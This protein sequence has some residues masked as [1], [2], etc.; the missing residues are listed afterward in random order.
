MTL[1]PSRR[2]SFSLK[3]GWKKLMGQCYR[4]LPGQFPGGDAMNLKLCRFT[5]E[6]GEAVWINPLQI[7]MVHRAQPRGSQTGTR[8]EF[9]EPQYVFVRESPEEVASA[10]EA[11]VFRP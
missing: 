2:F 5:I 7:R 10:V 11:A 9:N 3:E 8:I 4:L 1:A 6:S